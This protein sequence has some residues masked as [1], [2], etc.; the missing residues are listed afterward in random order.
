MRVWHL[1][2]HE[3]TAGRTGGRAPAVWPL[4]IGSTGER[5]RRP[6]R[7]PHSSEP[8]AVWSAAQHHPS[9]LLGKRWHGECRPAAA[10]LRSHWGSSHPEAPGPST[11]SAFLLPASL[12]LREG[13]VTSHGAL[14]PRDIPPQEPQTGTN[15]SK[16][17]VPST[18]EGAEKPPAPSRAGDGVPL[19]EQSPGPEGLVPW[20]KL[21][22]GRA[23][24]HHTAHAQTQ[25]WP[26]LAKLCRGRAGAVSFPA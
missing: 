16:F 13:E 20:A 21:P 15:Q 17:S 4:F 8:Q 5:R 11:L 25:T 3:H 14:V 10:R 24:R 1:C 7:A 19:A 12:S 26:S 22:L 23:L 9:H 6:F 2:T 18:A